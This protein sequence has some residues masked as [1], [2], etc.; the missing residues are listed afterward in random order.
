MAMC[1]TPALIQFLVMLRQQPIDTNN[2]VAYKGPPFF[3]SRTMFSCLFNISSSKL[4]LAS[5]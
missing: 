2:Q 1:G 5:V 3:Q 4:F